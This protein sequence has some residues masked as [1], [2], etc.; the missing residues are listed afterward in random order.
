MTKEVGIECKGSFILGIPGETID[1]CKKTIEFTMELSP[2]F[3]TFYSY[4]SV[5]GSQFYGQEKKGLLKG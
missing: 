3:A 4:D 2:D 1:D 5:L